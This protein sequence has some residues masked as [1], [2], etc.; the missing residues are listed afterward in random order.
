MLNKK[1]VTLAEVIISIALIS[2]VLVF[3]IKLLIEL[4]NM[5]TNNIFAKN[6][7][8][9]RAEILRTINNDLLDKTL[10][11]ISS[12]NSSQNELVITF[13]FS[14][15]ISQIEATSTTFR[16]IVYAEDGSTESVR[17]WDM[18]DCDVYVERANLYY[19]KDDNIFTLNLNIQI[20]TANDQ[21]NATTNNI[22]DDINLSYIG[23][24]SDF[25]LDSV[26]CLGYCCN[27]QC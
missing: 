6:N 10:V 4:N 19:I 20:H 5:E 27:N 15:S 8:V 18:N 25:I 3:M 7:Q 12:T 24:S 21:N 1:G 13:E 14:D 26:Y 22:L 2:V 16:Y 11:N 9:N 17:T 23:N